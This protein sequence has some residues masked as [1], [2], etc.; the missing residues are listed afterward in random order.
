MESIKVYFRNAL[1]GLA[2]M[3]LSNF[4]QGNTTIQSGNVTNVEEDDDIHMYI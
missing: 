3:I 1:I 2:T 4:Q